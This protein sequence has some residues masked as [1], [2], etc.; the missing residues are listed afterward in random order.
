MGTRFSGS[1]LFQVSVR[2]P[3]TSDTRPLSKR[4]GKGGERQD[5]DNTTRILIWAT[6]PSATRTSGPHTQMEDGQIRRVLTEGA[7]YYFCTQGGRAKGTLPSARDG[8]WS[9]RGEV[10]RRHLGPYRRARLLVSLGSDPGDMGLW[11]HGTL[12]GFWV[13]HLL[14]TLLTPQT[15]IPT[16]V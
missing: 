10:P 6:R 2:H 16:L 9:T 12:K 5:S 8:P 1:S 15:K 3:Y 14:K 13:V 11:S 4:D 7:R